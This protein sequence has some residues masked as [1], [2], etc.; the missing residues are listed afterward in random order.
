MKTLFV[1]LCAVG[2]VFSAQADGD[3]ARFVSPDRRFGVRLVAPDPG[4][5]GE[6]TVNL[7]DLKSGEVVLEIDSLGGSWIK[8]I[9]LLWAADSQRAAFLSPDR[10]GGWTKLFVR[11]G[12]TFEELQLPD[13]PSLDFH[14]Q[15]G[16][17]TITAGRVPIRWIKPNLLLIEHESED[18]D[19][20]SGRER[21]TIH[22]DEKNQLKVTPVKK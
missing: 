6:T 1:L 12:N 4:E 7:V 20:N 21:L 9:R 3:R 5:S 11:H 19:G 14:H 15:E 22:F 8:D 18:A 17:K 13:L 2:V 16:V 10:R